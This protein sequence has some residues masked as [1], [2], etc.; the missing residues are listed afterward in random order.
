MALSFASMSAS[1]KTEIQALYGVA[2]DPTKLQK[3][4]DALGKAIVENIQA[5]AQVTV[6]VTTVQA[7]TS[8]APG[9]GTVS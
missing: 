3:F 9:T 8:T 4:C 5:N 1:I 2:D 6:T 7:G